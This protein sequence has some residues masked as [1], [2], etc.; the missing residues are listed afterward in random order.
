MVSQRFLDA[1]LHVY[2]GEQFG[3]AVFETLLPQAEDEE[4]RYVLGT[5]LQLE[6]EGKAVMRPMLS[7]LGCFGRSNPGRSDRCC[8]GLV[9]T[10]AQAGLRKDPLSQSGL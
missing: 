9:R 3:E 8:L 2:H 6:S 1:L 4:Q 10:S 5:L 7:K